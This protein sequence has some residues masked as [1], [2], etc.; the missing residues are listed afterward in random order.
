[1]EI[2][3]LIV[4]LALGGGVAWHFYRQHRA[5]FMRAV[6]LEAEKSDLRVEIGRLQEV[7]KQVGRLELKQAELEDD[8]SARNDQISD[9]REKLARSEEEQESTQ[10]AFAEAKDQ[11]EA[12]FKD[13]AN[14]AMNQSA[15]Q[16]L[17][18]ASER[19]DG[20]T[21][22][23]RSELEKRQLAIQD[24]VK[25]IEEKLGKLDESHR[26]IEEKRREE[27]GTLTEQV[28]QMM[29]QSRNVDKSTRDLIRALR[30]P[31]ERGRWG[32]VQLRRVVEFAGMIEHCD[33][34]T[35]VTGE[36]DAGGR[37]RPDMIVHVPG[38]R[39]IIVD[40]KVPFDAYSK[41]I[42]ADDDDLRREHMIS[43]A[44]QVRNHVTKLGQRGYQKQFEGALDFVVLFVPADP[45][46]SHALE[47]DGSLWED[48]A[49][50]GVMLCTPSTLIVMLRSA[51]TLWR[52]EQV[53][54]N[55]KEISDLGRDLYKRLG[56]L[57]DHFG[58]V[59][60][61][62]NQAVNSYNQAIGALESRVL[63]G[64]R[65]FKE[66]DTHLTEEID[67]LQPVDERT[68]VIQS[69]ELKALKPPDD[70]AIGSL[71]EPN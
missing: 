51:A 4:G 46:L 25:P 27:Y 20:L 56:T 45:M 38:G 70:R 7:E 53:R 64:A 67:E 40:A 32:E 49:Q 58:K 16:F 44:R 23:Q 8:L 36:S 63:P 14:Q 22:E 43:H 26:A 37:L 21:K 62:L 31:G 55:A 71:F 60:R 2:V 19:F 9:Y 47:H 52:Q 54:Q 3:F 35:Q 59:G 65:K 57:S 61:N 13:L 5:E 48:A 6:A 39:E 33:F 17:K 1:M 18:L 10:R 24:L 68:R 11:F 12:V 30:N 29:D 66:L 50:S 41:A 42:E 69:P 34:N 15:E 28:K